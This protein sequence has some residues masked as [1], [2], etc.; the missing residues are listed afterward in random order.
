MKPPSK[1][2]HHHTHANPGPPL[3][4]SLGATG[5]VLDSPL[6]L[7]SWMSTPLANS[8]TI[9][10]TPPPPGYT[11]PLTSSD[12]NVTVSLFYNQPYRI[13]VYGTHCE[14]TGDSVSINYTIGESV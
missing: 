8:Y 11:G 5:S 2:Y 13:S 7:L 10:I 4:S 9:T 1:L 14:T 12:T 3:V 6:T